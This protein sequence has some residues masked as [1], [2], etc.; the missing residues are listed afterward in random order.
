M[1][2]DRDGT[3]A[4]DVGYL[5][6][7]A[8]LELL[9]GLAEALRDLRAGGFALVVV[10]NQSGVARG[11][12]SLARAHEIMGRLRRELRGL[13]VELDGVYF[14]P[15]LPEQGCGCRKPGAALLLRA[16]EDLN[17]SLRHSVMVGDKRLDVEAAHRAGSAGVLVRTGYGRQEEARAATEGP[18]PDAV[19][20]DLG[21]AAKWILAR[22]AIP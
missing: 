16:A 14:C 11:F 21:E 22:A 19:C 7:P 13:G 17:L 8:A 20:D 2:L 1:F 10:S 5:S 15:H 9:P 12:F 18:P 4:R 3:L 6:D